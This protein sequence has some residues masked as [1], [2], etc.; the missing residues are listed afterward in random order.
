[1]ELVQVELVH[2]LHALR[3]LQVYSRARGLAGGQLEEGDHDHQQHHLQHSHQYH[4]H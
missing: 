4:H 2:A 3:L 1:M